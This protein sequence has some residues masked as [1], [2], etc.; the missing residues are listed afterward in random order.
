MLCDELKEY[1]NDDHP[2]GPISSPKVENQDIF[3]HLF[4]TD[5]VLYSEMS[6]HPSLIIGRRGAGK[7]ALLHSIYMGSHYKYVV[8]L[9]AQ[10]AFRKVVI[11]IQ[12]MGKDDVFVEEVAE[13]WNIIF[14]V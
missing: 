2:L 1:Y 6:R 10:I 14:W 9:P 12:E 3:Q 4:D 11:S 7:T 13:L 5:N 8:E